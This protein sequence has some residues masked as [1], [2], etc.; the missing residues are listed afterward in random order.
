MPLQPGD[1]R[2]PGP[3]GHEAGGQLPVVSAATRIRQLHGLIVVGDDGLRELDRQGV[4]QDRGQL[5]AVDDSDAVDPCGQSIGHRY[6]CELWTL[7]EH[8]VGHCEVTVSGQQL[9]QGAGNHRK[10]SRLVIGCRQQS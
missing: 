10:D 4:E 3:L 1:L 2:R 6:P 7:E 9:E 8:C 5:D